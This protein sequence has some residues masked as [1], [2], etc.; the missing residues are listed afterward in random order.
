[1]RTIKVSPSVAAYLNKY[2]QAAV[3]LINDELVPLAYFVLF[4]ADQV[5]PPTPNPND[6]RHR[7]DEVTVM[8]LRHGDDVKECIFE[9][10]IYP[11]VRQHHWFVIEF[12]QDGALFSNEGEIDDVIFCNT[13]D[14]TW[15]ERRAPHRKR[16]RAAKRRK[17]EERNS[18]AS[19]KPLGGVQ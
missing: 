2:R 12:G 11:K 1:M 17:R 7:D 16:L 6:Y 8:P 19:L 18:L 15:M 4:L 10:K 14:A 5:F 3:T 9:R 13:D